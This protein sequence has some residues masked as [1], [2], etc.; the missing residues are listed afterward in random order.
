MVSSFR[1]PID[2]G[3]DVISFSARYN[4]RNDGNFPI[5]SGIA[6]I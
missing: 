4:N 1:F 2:D 5:V 6:L 3:R